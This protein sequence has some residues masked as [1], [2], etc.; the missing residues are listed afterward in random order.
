M[1]TASKQTG[2]N[3]PGYRIGLFVVAALYERRS[4]ESA[5]TDRRYSFPR[6]AHPNACARLPPITKNPQPVTGRFRG[7]RRFK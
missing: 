1:H 7:I 6:L 5:V 4:P 2:G 3:D